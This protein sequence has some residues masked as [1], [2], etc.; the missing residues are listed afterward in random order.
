MTFMTTLMRL[1]VRLAIVAVAL[2][3]SFVGV[4]AAV[5]PGPGPS[6]PYRTGVAPVEANPPVVIV[7]AAPPKPDSSL[8]NLPARTL[9]GVQL[10]GD[11][12]FFHDWRIQRNSLTGHC[13][14]LDGDDRRHAW[15]SFEQCQAKLQEIKRDRNLPPM[16]GRA[17]VLLHGLGAFRATMNP[18]ADFLAADGDVTIINVTYPSTRG[19]LS[20]H[21]QALAS[22]VRHLDGIETIDFVGHSLGNI[23][24]RYFMADIT[25]KRTGALADPRIRRFVM[26]AP[27]NHGAEKADKWSDSDLFLAVLGSSAV[28]LGTGWPDV[29]RHLCTPPCEFG[30]IAG[31]KGD[32]EG[33]TSSIAGD[34]DGLISLAT[35][36]LAGASD[37]VVIPQRH[38]LLLFDAEVTRYT[39][40]FLKRGYFITPERQHPL[41]RVVQQ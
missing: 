28:Q 21:A 33:F 13:R 30:I 5:E 11:E 8:V 31:G 39:A 24:I 36:K 10:W 4:A 38:T 3:T 32:H 40:R 6:I 7:P 29:E 15:G 18:I 1:P 37:Y 35:T 17:V 12:L 16:H 20:Q 26:V 41:P 25:D 27:P 14:L 2:L 22:I 34:D 9:G 23:V 19:D